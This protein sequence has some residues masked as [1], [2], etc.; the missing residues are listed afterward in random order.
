MAQPIE[1]T[2][3]M[4]LRLKKVCDDILFERDVNGL[5]R[6]RSLPFRLKYRLGKNMT[7]IDK[8]T[9]S[10]MQNQLYFK[11]TFGTENPETHEVELDEEGK[12]KFEQAIRLLLGTKV[13]INVTVLEPEDI[14]LLTHN[15]SATIEDIRIFT[16]FMMNEPEFFE[17]I[18]S[19][20]S[21]DLTRILEDVEKNL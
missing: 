11:A 8:Y 21:I 16:A 6:E 4:I 5:V 19:R 13:T 10:F 15:T 9:S 20:V 7:H 3:G 17:D 2:I 18:N 12:K 14:E 1:L